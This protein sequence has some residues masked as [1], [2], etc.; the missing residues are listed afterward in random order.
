MRKL[1]LLVF[2][3]L[4]GLLFSQT[5]FHDTQGSIDVNG[6]GQLQFNLPIALP[7]GVKSVAPQMNLVYTGGYG[8]G[9]AGYGWSLSGIT[10]ISRMGKTLETDG[11]IKGIQLDY[12]DY[13]SF[14]GQ[15]LILKS[16]EYGKDGAEYVSEKY[17]NVKI[18]SLGQA[19]NLMGQPLQMPKYWEVTF[20]NGSQA[21]Y[22]T[23]ADNL[24]DLSKTLIEYNITKWKD[25]NGNYITYEYNQDILGDKNVA[26]IKKISWGGNETLGKSHFN[27]IQFNYILRDIKE[28]AY[29]SNRQFIQDQLLSSIF[30]K[31]NG[32]QFKK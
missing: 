5:N 30:V 16:G 22:G 24:N 23:N 21:W 18:K 9:I 10:S 17:S 13:Y 3:Y 25:V 7:P 27:E 31:T 32:S 15:R 14:N 2:L 8:N 20:E 12:S 1:Y 26:V 28:A 6:G 11:E 29:V 19:L 4:T